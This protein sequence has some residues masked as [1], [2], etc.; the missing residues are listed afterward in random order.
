VC[1]RWL[2]K[3]FSAWCTSVGDI[4]GFGKVQVT[5]CGLSKSMFIWGFL[6]QEP[7]RSEK[8]KHLRWLKLQNNSKAKK[9]CLLRFATLSLLLMLAFYATDGCCFVF[10]HCL[11]WL[12][13]LCLFLSLVQAASLFWTRTECFGKELRFRHSASEHSL[14]LIIRFWPEK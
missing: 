10:T 8:R 1:V 9:N 11:S 5:F 7:I 13:V 6:F 4:H 3:L 12:I 14:I 2:R